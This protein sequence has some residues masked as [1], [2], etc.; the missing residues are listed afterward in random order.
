MTAG[1]KEFV[2]INPLQEFELAC[3][4]NIQILSPL[5]VAHATADKPH[6]GHNYRLTNYNTRSL[7][8]E[9]E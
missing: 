3:M 4:G 2:L 7:Q 5:R 1:Q 9:E 8:K 6:K